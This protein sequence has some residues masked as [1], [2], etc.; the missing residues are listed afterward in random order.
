[1]QVILL[2]PQADH[3]CVAL[4][5]QESSHIV[6]KWMRV[7][8][9]GIMPQDTAGG[10]F[11][12][13][14]QQ[15]QHPLQMVS[16]TH[17]RDGNYLNYPDMT[18]IYEKVDINDALSAGR[19]FLQHR[20]RVLAKLQPWAEHCAQ[21]GSY[22]A[23]MIVL[24]T[25]NQAQIDILINFVCSTRYHGIDTSTILLFAMDVATK[26][27]A[28]GLGITAFYDDKVRFFLS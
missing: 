8:P 2:Q 28:E 1:M 14:N 10:A 12:Q 15:V 13:P 22:F 23:K 20:I 18:N 6:Y 5:G 4:V 25:C 9:I 19:Q 27:V 16:R 11:F 7:A 26:E 24:M 17:Q 21:P 3:H